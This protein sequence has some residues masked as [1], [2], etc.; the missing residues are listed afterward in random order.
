M[1][2]VTAEV[3]KEVMQTVAGGVPSFEPFL[4]YHSFGESSINLSVIVRVRE[5]VDQYH[6]KHEFIKKL[7]SRYQKEGIVFPYPIRAINYAQEKER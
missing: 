4:R 6:I 5:F 2:K 1:E 3:A 7:Y